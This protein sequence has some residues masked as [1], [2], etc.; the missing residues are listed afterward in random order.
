MFVNS[1][2]H[3]L[4]GDIIII[5]LALISNKYLALSYIHCVVTGKFT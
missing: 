5:C 4:S 3:V 2:G 1:D